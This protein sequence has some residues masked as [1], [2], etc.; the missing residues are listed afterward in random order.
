MS[1]ES[2]E[3]WSCCEVALVDA[4]AGTGQRSGRAV[5]RRVVGELVG[6]PPD[7]GRGARPAAAAL[8]PAARPRLPA[9]PSRESLPL[10]Q[11][12]SSSSLPQPAAHRGEADQ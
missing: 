12:R 10:L 1:R 7:G 6:V 4:D 3:N 11:P 9:P 8:H 5:W 2:C